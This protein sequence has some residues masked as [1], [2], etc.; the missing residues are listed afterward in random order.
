MGFSHSANMACIESYKNGVMKT[1]ELM[2]VG[3]WFIE[4]VEMLKHCP[5]LDVGIHLA[6][7]SE[8][9]NFK[10]RPLTY[11]PSLVDSNGYF[12]PMVWQNKNY[13]KNASIQKANWNIDEIEQELRAQI[14][15][16]L[17]HLQTLIFVL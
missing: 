7:T 12:F 3:A 5:G 2:P 1:V 4:A 13:S 16:A 10:W 9:S 17:K 15:L 8:W 14:E 11:V 6:L